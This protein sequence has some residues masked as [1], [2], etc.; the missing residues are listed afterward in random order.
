M[1]EAVPTFRRSDIHADGLQPLQSLSTQVELPHSGYDDQ[2]LGFTAASTQQM[3]LQPRFVTLSTRSREHNLYTTDTAQ[4]IAASIAE[5]NQDSGP[6]TNDAASTV[7]PVFRRDDPHRIV[8]LAVPNH[9]RNA[10]GGDFGTDENIPPSVSDPKQS[11]SFNQ[12]HDTHYFDALLDDEDFDVIPD[13]LGGAVDANH[14]P[15]SN[16]EP[17]FHFENKQRTQR[18]GRAKGPKRSDF[19]AVAEAAPAPQPVQEDMNVKALATE[20]RRHEQ[21]KSQAQVQPARPRTPQGNRKEV[22]AAGAITPMRVPDLLMQ[23]NAPRKSTV[24]RRKPQQ[25]VEARQTR[26]TTKAAIATQARSKSSKHD[27]SSS[28]HQYSDSLEEDRRA[29]TP[30][31]SEGGLTFGGIP[32]HFAKSKINFG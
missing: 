29:D 16:E 2:E 22:A 17:V 19:P 27:A 14:V 13:T 32:F 6:Y 15:E 12:P 10:I 7:L 18:S 1:A 9:A 21:K 25:A 11:S 28:S 3:T 4:K 30:A 20:I 26:S 31:T 24:A 5:N 8:S 23:S